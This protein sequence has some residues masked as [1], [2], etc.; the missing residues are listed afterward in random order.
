MD[1]WLCGRVGFSWVSV[2]GFV[3]GSSWPEV[4]V[5]YA[6]RHTTTAVA[7]HKWFTMCSRKNKQ[8]NT[9]ESRPPQAF[10][11][12]QQWYYSNSHRKLDPTLHRGH[13]S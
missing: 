7:L 4:F 6:V 8:Q 10:H 5:A 13:R 2:V 11:S 9:P 12:I 1:W 3:Y